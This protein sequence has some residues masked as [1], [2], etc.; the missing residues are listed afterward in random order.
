MKPK[1]DPWIK[2]PKDRI[3]QVFAFDPSLNLD[4]NMAVINRL[5]LRVPWEKL[6]RGPVGDYLEV[7]DVDPASG[8]VYPPVDLNDHALLVQ[9]GLAP[10]EGTPQFHQQMVY[11][12]AS[13]TIYNFE[14]ALGR[15][16]IWS[17]YTGGG[18]LEYVPRLRLY[19]HALREANAYYSP[20]KK[21]ILFGYFPASTRDAGANLPGGTVFSCLSHDIIAHETTHALL[22]SLR[23]YFNEPSNPDV[24]ALHEAFADIVAL[25]QHFSYP[26]VLRSQIARTR[27]NLTDENL[28]GEL[29]Q[30]F[31]Q[32]IGQRGALRSAIGE[33]DENGVWRPAKPDPT[34]IQKTFEPHARGSILVAAVFDAFLTV[35]QTRTADLLRI[36]TSGSGLLAEGA[37]HPDLVNRL[38]EEAARISRHI[39]NICVRALDYCP[40]FDLTFGEYLRAIITADF[41]MVPVDSEGYRIAFIEAFRRRGIYPTGVRNLSQE[42]LLWI[43]PDDD[44]IRSDFFCESRL[45]EIKWFAGTE[46]EYDDQRSHIF[47]YDLAFRQIL[48]DWLTVDLVNQAGP[49]KVK[50]YRESLCLYLTLS[51]ADRLE[52]VF[53]ENDQPLVEINSVRPAYR[54]SPVGLTV[55]DL[56]V[57]VIQKRRGYFDRDLQKKVDAGEIDPPEPDFIFRGGA[58]LLISSDTGEVRYVIGKR[59]GSNRRLETQRLY[60]TEDPS[61]HSLRATYFG[62]P[63][64]SAFQA[65]GGSVELFAM[66]HRGTPGGE[67]NQ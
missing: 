51:K 56:V 36:A 52:S 8:F 33:N 39:L 45:A 48:H 42:S 24:L 15:P 27:G 34:R 3:L 32:A 53:K 19:P 55:A 57:Q 17:P 38:A 1:L 30:Q 2:P 10:S 22:D 12:V 31:G 64:T 67:V 54:I 49:D 47:T 13:R 18:G 14:R 63:L 20:N 4:I 6:E 16:V 65:D 7:V 59:V 29:A 46:K 11:A 25:F 9:D 23:P 37:I 44:S 66:L 50:D 58:T 5:Y 43:P 28:L 62:S 60:L 26:D 61:Q 21:A 40:P 41:D 35:Y